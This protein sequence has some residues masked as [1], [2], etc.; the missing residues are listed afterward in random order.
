[1]NPEISIDR[2]LT[3]Q[4]CFIA[5]GSKQY[6]GWAAGS[7]DVWDGV[8]LGGAAAGEAAVELVGVF[9]EHGEGSIPR[10]RA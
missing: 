10:L 7:C 5:V 8:A 3:L 4:S 1:M 6:N 2:I 9:P